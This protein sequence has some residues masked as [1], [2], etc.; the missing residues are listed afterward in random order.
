MN[1]IEILVVGAIVLL[2]FGFAGGYSIADIVKGD[3]LAFGD[4]D[5][6]EIDDLDGKDITLTGDVS[7][8]RTVTYNLVRAEKKGT[9]VN[10]GGYW[11]LNGD[12]KENDADTNAPA[13]TASYG[14]D[15]VLLVS[16]GTSPISGYGEKYMGS[17]P[18]TATK[19]HE[20]DI[21]LVDSSATVKM[22][23]DDDGNLLSSSNPEPVAASDDITIEGSIRASADKLFGGTCDSHMVVCYDYNIT[24]Y[25]DITETLHGI[26]ANIPHH[27]RATVEGCFE[28]PTTA[29]SG[30][31]FFDTRIQV[32]SAADAT[33]AGTNFTTYFVDKDYFRHTDD[34]TIHCGTNDNDNTELG[35]S[36]ITSTI[37]TS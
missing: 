25:T 1:L 7:T 22:W 26:D 27:L 13:I 4:T 12:Y 5:V 16:N 28:I 2:V 19:T 21:W 35:F 34:L 23:S 29:D 32:A 36:D 11:Y 17:M 15:Y 10:F 37:Y 14:D 18:L 3:A 33:G 31:S 8:T 6:D 24:E 20:V 30:K 9:S